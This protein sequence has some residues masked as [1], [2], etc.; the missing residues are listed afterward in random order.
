MGVFIQSNPATEAFTETRLFFAIFLTNLNKMARGKGQNRVAHT[1]FSRI[2][3]AKIAP[4]FFI[5]KK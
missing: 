4:V 3:I 2:H 5:F 1:L